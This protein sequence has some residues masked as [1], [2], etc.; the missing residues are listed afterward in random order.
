MRNIPQNE[1]YSYRYANRFWNEFNS[2]LHKHVFIAFC[3]FAF[4]SGVK[5]VKLRHISYR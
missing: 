5:I 3:D 2:I 1:E 4:Y